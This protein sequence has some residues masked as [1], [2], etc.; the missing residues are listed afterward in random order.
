MGRND[1]GTTELN[2]N[3]RNVEI[4]HVRIALVATVHHPK[5]PIKIGNSKG[6]PGSINPWRFT[7]SRTSPFRCHLR[8]SHS[9]AGHQSE[10]QDCQPAVENHM[11]LGGDSGIRH[12]R[13]YPDLNLTYLYLSIQR[14]K[15]TSILYMSCSI[16][17][18]VYSKYSKFEAHVKLQ[19]S[20]TNLSSF[21]QI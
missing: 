20:I 15:Y 12:V 3:N 18:N 9:N 1:E 14:Y 6:Y 16:H 4:F 13:Q 17:R 2:A 21:L 11:I 8:P 5:L 10:I 7:T 19:V